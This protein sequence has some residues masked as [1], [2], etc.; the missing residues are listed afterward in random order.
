[1][2]IVEGLIRDLRPFSK[3]GLFYDSFALVC[4]TLRFNKCLKYSNF[5]TIKSVKDENRK[6]HF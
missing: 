5:E 4:S 2:H 1:M 3:T 6:K